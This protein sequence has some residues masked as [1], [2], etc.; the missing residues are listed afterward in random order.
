MSN[1]Q[2]GKPPGSPPD[3]A[4]PPQT[5]TAPGGH[6][7]APPRQLPQPFAH[8]QPPAQAMWPP[9]RSPFAQQ[10]APQQPA[11]QQP[12][13]Q[14]PY[15]QQPAQPYAAPSQPPPSQPSA[16]P[17]AAYPASQPAAYPP[18]HPAAYP[19][20]QPPPAQ[21]AAYP[22]SQPPPSQPAAYPQ[23][24][25][26]APAPYPP[27]P[28]PSQP[29]AY[30]PSQ[31]PPAQAAP[32]APSQPPP[33]YAVAPNAAMPPPDQTVGFQVAL[34]RAM[35]LR[36][37]PHEVTAGE[38]AA[39][40]AGGVTDPYLQ[41]F[42]AWRRSVLTLVAILLVPL[43]IVRLADASNS[44]LPEDLRFIQILPAA[45]EGVLCAM[46]WYQ[47]RNWTKW[48]TQ[49]RTLLITWLVFMA[50][51]F[52]VFLVPIEPIL[53]GILKKQG[54]RM[55]DL[56]PAQLAEVTAVKTALSAYALITLAPKAVSLLAGVTRAGVVTKMLFPGSAGPG[57]LIVLA[58]PI[59][60]LF[61]FTL[62]IVP[63]QITGSG[64][65]VGAMIALAVA[66]LSLGRAGYALAKPV[67]RQI[68]IDTIQKARATYLIAQVSF[69][70]CL[71]TALG[72]IAQSLALKTIVIT[73]LGFEANVLILTLI[74]SDLVITN[75]DRG[76]GV[77][78]GTT[79]LADET[80]QKLDTFVGVKS[81]FANKPP[82]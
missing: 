63:Y 30:P 3:P 47:L 19:P 8:Q 51:P 72:T 78:E 76:R 14:Q 42:L 74:G 48:R 1:Q 70:V 31:P 41:A 64:W 12:Y 65:L 82:G 69:G 80:N 25:Y 15:S 66:Q 81:P 10:P 23:Q 4:A 26:G 55:A 79:Q 24:A 59:Y 40:H 60:T 6:N 56:S 33:G 20:S 43:T 73:V 54:V 2:G 16:Y 39:L 28:P 7:P 18:S 45:L 5:T 52:L 49:R 27:Q 53:E 17:P 21:P 37:E 22:P 35:R 32:F 34:K 71:I 68:A 13:P 29:A 46:C 62:L 58:A 36:I 38:R 61:V 57:W 9:P 75:L 44:Q 11:P 67:T 77:S 50:G